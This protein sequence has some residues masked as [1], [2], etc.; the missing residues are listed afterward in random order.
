MN[1]CT[2]NGGRNI[3]VYSIN[4]DVQSYVWGNE[5]IE[6]NSLCNVFWQ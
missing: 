3:G 5:V 1:M 4:V 6:F 2:E